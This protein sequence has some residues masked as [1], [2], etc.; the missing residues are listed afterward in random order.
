MDLL[1]GFDAISKVCLCSSKSTLG[2]RLQ[3]HQLAG[4]GV[5]LTRSADLLSKMFSK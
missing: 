4:F 1:R 3:F 5:Q 2:K